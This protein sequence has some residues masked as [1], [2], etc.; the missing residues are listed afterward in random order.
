MVQAAIQLIM[1]MHLREG[2]GTTQVVNMLFSFF[3]AAVIV[4]GSVWVM[5]STMQDM[6]MDNMEMDNMNEEQGHNM[7]DSHEGHDME[8]EGHDSH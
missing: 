6:D 8:D 7:D 3:I 1:F 2:E 4:A 5:M